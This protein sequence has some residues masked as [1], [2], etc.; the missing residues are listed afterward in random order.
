MTPATALRVKTL[1]SDHAAIKARMLRSVEQFKTERGYVPPYWELVRL[2]REAK[3]EL[4]SP[5]RPAVSSQ[6]SRQ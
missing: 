2:A 1:K 3:V 6:V 4:R 5:D